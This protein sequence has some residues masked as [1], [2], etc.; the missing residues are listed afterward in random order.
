LDTLLAFQSHWVI[1][2][3][4]TL[5]L[6]SFTKIVLECNT[7][8]GFAQSMKHSLTLQPPLRFPA[9]IPAVQQ[10]GN[11][12]PMTAPNP[13]AL[14]AHDLRHA[15][16]GPQGPLEVLH[17][18]GFSL[19]AGQV[20]AVLGPSGSGK[21]T[22]LHLL[23]GLET[24][25]SGEVIWG[26]RSLKNASQDALAARRAQEVGFIFQHHYLLE[27]LTALENVTVPSLIANKPDE[28]RAR[29]LLERVSLQ[30]RAGFYPRALSGGERQR[31][32]LARALVTRPRLLL[33]DEPTGSL[34]RS[35]AERVFHLLV[36][37]SH[38]EG[39][40]VVVVTHDEVL[41]QRADDIIQ[42]QDGR[43]LEHVPYAAQIT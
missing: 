20:L 9:G 37:L 17:G 22:L 2:I 15:Y 27:D 32:A 40:A 42:L 4:C 10:G 13:P 1:A 5:E 29:T 25:S 23:G 14:E 31:V 19:Q 28:A 36:E 39:T 24:P 21:S 35:N 7:A 16:P 33:A 3:T 6:F 30:S 12:P 8:P 41:A 11:I 26:G 43:I 18:I 38:D 34:D